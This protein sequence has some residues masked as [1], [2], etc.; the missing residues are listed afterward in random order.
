M[1]LYDYHR[2]LPWFDQPDTKSVLK[3]K[4]LTPKECLVFVNIYEKS[5]TDFK[6]NDELKDF[7]LNEE[8]IKHLIDVHDINLKNINY[9]YLKNIPIISTY[10]YV[11][12]MGP[13]QCKENSLPCPIKLRIFMKESI[14]DYGYPEEIFKVVITRMNWYFNYFGSSFLI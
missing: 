3:L 13:Y 9:T 6:S 8:S 7:N 1:E 4:V 10:L 14:K 11:L 12:C 5:I 2:L